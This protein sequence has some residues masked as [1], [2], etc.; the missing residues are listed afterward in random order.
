MKPTF[1]STAT[2]AKY[3][4]QNSLTQLSG[5]EVISRRCNDGKE[6]S[7][8]YQWHVHLDVV[9]GNP[10]I[11]ARVEVDMGPSF[12]RKS[13]YV[14]NRPRK[15]LVQRRNIGE[16]DRKK[17]ENVP[18]NILDPVWRC[19]ES[20]QV[21][22]GW[23]GT[24]W[25]TIV[26]IRGTVL[27]VKYNAHGD[28]SDLI[29]GHFYEEKT[30]GP[31]HLEPLPLPSHLGFQVQLH[32]ENN[33]LALDFSQ[34]LYGEE[35]ISV[36]RDRIAESSNIT[37]N[38]IVSASVK[39]TLP[40]NS[41][42][43]DLRKVALNFIKYEE[44]MDE[45]LRRH[46]GHNHPTVQPTGTTILATSNRAIVPGDT[47]K[48]KHD[49]LLDCKSVVELI[50]LLNPN[51]TMLTST[52]R[53]KLNLGQTSETNTCDFFFPSIIGNSDLLQNLTRWSVCFCHNSIRFRTPKCLRSDRTVDEQIE[54][55]FDHAIRDRFV[56]EGLLQIHSLSPDA[57]QTTMMNLSDCM[58]G[59]TLPE[60]VSSNIPLTV[61][62]STLDSESH[63]PDRKRQR[64][65][66]PGDHPKFLPEMET[67]S[68]PMFGDYVIFDC[69]SSKPPVS[70]LRPMLRQYLTD[71]NNFT[72]S[73]LTT[74]LKKLS[75][76]V[77]NQK[78][79][80]LRCLDQ[81]FVSRSLELEHIFHQ[82]MPEG[83]S[84]PPLPSGI[85][86]IELLLG[87]DST[88]DS[89][90]MILRGGRKAS[91]LR[92]SVDASK[93]DDVEFGFL[94][95]EEIERACLRIGI[96]V[97]ITHIDA[98]METLSSKSSKEE[99]CLACSFALVH[100]LPCNI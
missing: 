47:N 89:I 16:D 48:R 56:E 28:R 29:E 42:L 63:S 21:C 70:S 83:T 36:L 60:S 90:T 80:R 50:Q 7:F 82:A 84:L 43:E 51:D 13:R 97:G 37:D 59:L 12:Q 54:C 20:K 76:T 34:P 26:G 27:K 74:I 58:D 88:S 85:L 24:I 67:W 72:S 93:Q 17:E 46:R 94:T 77:A 40:Y 61:F 81:Y 5:G 22:W 68:S 6:R 25:F 92:V 78:L 87:E 30:E 66:G 1:N 39:V 75:I 19:F 31:S 23:P 96:P 73:Q 57:D 38:H 91:R 18:A 64:E 69:T 86:G 41:N 10:D 79:K 44:A 11:I 55:L 33:Q 14:Q 100:D 32:L 9:S 8:R 3:V 71:E 99:H 52:E 98:F 35:G 65:G 15:V 4:I 95:K 49:K 62:C 2:H 53:Y 45:I